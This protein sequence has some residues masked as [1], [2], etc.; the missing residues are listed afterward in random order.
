M[1]WLDGLCHRVR[2]VLKPGDYEHELREEMELHQAL[3]AQQLGDRDS[4]RR[5]FGNRTFHQEETRRMTWL[6]HLD[7]LRQDLGYTW[8]AVRRSPGFTVM[9]VITLALGIGLNAA[10]F[11][12]VDQLYL[13]PPPG[14]M[15]PGDVRRVWIESFRVAGRASSTRQAVNYPMFRAMATSY[16]DTSRFAA[17]ATMGGY[18]LGGTRRGPLVDVVYV[19]S[20]YFPL[21]GVRPALGR[22]FTADE[23]QA[24]AARVVVVSHQLW[25]TDL[26]ADSSIVGRTILLDTTRYTVLGVAQQGFTGIDIDPAHLWIPLRTYPQADWLQG[27][28]FE[29][30]RMYIFRGF[31]RRAPGA[32]DEA[33]EQLASARLRQL[34]RE[35]WAVNPDTLLNVL[36]G[37]VLEARGPGDAEQ[38]YLITTRL[39]GVALMVLLIACANVVNLLLARAVA[40]RR[41]IA[42]RLALGISRARLIRLLTS[43]TVLLALLAAAAATL[44]AWW[45]GTALRALLLPEVEWTGSAM[46]WRVVAFSVGIAVLAGVV[47]G[48]IPAVQFSNPRMARSLKDGADAAASGRSTLRNGLLVVQVALSVMLLVG[49]GLFVRSLHNVQRIDIGYDARQLFMGRVA[50]E[51]GQAPPLAVRAE[52]IRSAQLRLRSRA[53][54]EGTARAGNE[55]MRGL[56]FKTF[57][58]GSDSSQSITRDFPTF[59]AVTPDYFATTGVR[60]L[61]GRLFDDGAAAEHQLVINEAM[62]AKLWPGRDALGQCVRFMSRDAQCHTVIGVVENSSQSK[63][64]ETAQPHYYLALGTRAAEGFAGTALVVRASTSASHAAKREIASILQQEFPDGYPVVTPMSEYLEPEY[65]PWR[66]GASLFTGSGVLALLVAMAGIYS[67][68]AYAVTRRTREFGVRIALGARVSDVLRQVVEESLKVVLIGVAVGIALALAAGRFMAA[69]LF[70]VQPGDPSIL[71]L[72]SCMLL[73]VASVATL[74]PAWRAARVNPVEALRAE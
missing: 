32:G 11:S 28:L 43:E 71:L 37:P 31:Y 22:F 48:L 19:G 3:D 46:H 35:Q 5:R 58:W 68:I 50:F 61:R 49:A 73:V 34:S 51:P 7:V 55:P 18:R 26:G 21:L 57:Y 15:N 62:G 65:R 4:A 16:G 9:V 10:T 33:F 23:D 14:V 8:R 72:V 53:G 44:T 63:V 13:R 39:G 45:G 74:V 1:A 67:S 2:T 47:A 70:G 30:E 25:R 59:S 20:N 27:R 56:S 6:G 12:V 17:M 38:E 52:K 42:V 40:R 24:G 41:E 60:L 29:S 69:L 64:I 54:I 36:T 66:L